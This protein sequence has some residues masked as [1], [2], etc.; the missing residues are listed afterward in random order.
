[1]AWCPNPYEEFIYFINIIY[2]I[3]GVWLIVGYVASF[4]VALRCYRLEKWF[5][6]YPLLI[7]CTSFNYIYLYYYFFGLNNKNVCSDEF[8]K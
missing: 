6:R 4:I 3:L 8:I 5:F 1:M 2:F 7:V